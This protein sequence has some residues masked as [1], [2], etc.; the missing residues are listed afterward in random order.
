MGDRLIVRN[1][2]RCRFLSASPT[3]PAA[4]TVPVDYRHLKQERAVSIF[5][6]I[7]ADQ[8]FLAESL[9]RLAP[10]TS[11]ASLL[12]VSPRHL[13]SGKGAFDLFEVCVQY[14]QRSSISLLI[15]VCREPVLGELYR[16]IAARDPKLAH[17]HRFGT[18][19][20]SFQTVEGARSIFSVDF[21]EGTSLA[22]V[23]G[24]LERLSGT[25]G[26]TENHPLSRL[27]LAV[28][29]GE[30]SALTKAG[31]I[32]SEVVNAILNAKRADDAE[33]LQAAEVRLRQLLCDLDAAAIT[34]MFRFY[35]Q[36]GFMSSDPRRE[37]MIL[38]TDG[39]RALKVIDY[40]SMRHLPSPLMVLS[41]FYEIFEYQPKNYA[42]RG[43]RPWAWSLMKEKS[44]FF[45]AVVEAFGR[46]AGLDFL[47]HALDEFCAGHD[48]YQGKTIATHIV[49]FL[50]GEGVL[51]PARQYP[52]ATP[53]TPE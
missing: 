7:V 1:T 31:V 49:S 32:E 16:T 20:F 34:E 38:K 4:A 45:K 26:L 13:S 28:V 53:R 35:I 12:V 50:Q 37:N 30:L 14:E 51:P 27:P 52:V 24:T 8:S 10:E 21:H 25:P 17:A 2:G 47:Q 15:F 9:A 39:H 11:G 46:Q 41:Q 29:E 40:E 5:T 3:G 33:T 6:S 18:S 42:I 36:T 43:V 48:V 22:S 19:R 44:G 23:A